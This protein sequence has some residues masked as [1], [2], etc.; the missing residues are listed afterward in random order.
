MSKLP[1]THTES[2]KRGVVRKI[3][4]N[5]S[6]VSDLEHDFGAERE[7]FLVVDGVVLET[8]AVGLL[9]RERI[10]KAK[11]AILGRANQI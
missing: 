8:A 5:A 10:V 2:K 3:K 6:K 1:A 11:K 4:H 9:E 7:R